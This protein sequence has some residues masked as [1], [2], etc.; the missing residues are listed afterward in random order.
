MNKSKDSLVGI[1]G[2]GS[3]SRFL[4]ADFSGRVRG[5]QVLGPLNPNNLPEAT[6][7][8]TLRTGFAVGQ[9]TEG[10]VAAAFAGVAGIK[11]GED[12]RL[13]EQLATNCLGKAVDRFGAAN[14][15]DILLAGG[16]QGRP[17]VALI[18]GTGAHCLGRNE[19]GTLATCGGWGYLMDDCGDGYA[20]GTAALRIAVR[21]WDGRRERTSLANRILEYLGIDAPE[22][23]LR[24]VYNSD[25][26][27]E[28]IKD[29]AIMVTQAAKSGDAAAAEI[30]DEGCRRA[31]ELVAVTQAKLGLPA[32]VEIVITGGVAMQ[33]YV[34]PILQKAI[35]DHLPQGRISLPE[36][37][38]VAGAVIRAAQL[39][40][41]DVTDGFLKNL[42]EGINEYEQQLHGD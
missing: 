41:I 25:F 14:D 35:R 16:L 22:A 33:D 38:P 18:L 12:A 3:R 24:R 42:R 11:G 27:F 5:L 1:D 30:L 10:P 13:F 28:E 15:T 36:L 34:R 17:G 37:P 4:E 32:D 2:G 26:G 21:M 6:I 31:A 20:L 29:L 23:A 39:A 8:E 9:G 7:E 19:A 40:G